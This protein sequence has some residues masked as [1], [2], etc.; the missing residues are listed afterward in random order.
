MFEPT[1]TENKASLDRMAEALKEIYSTA[2]NDPTAFRSM[3]AT[4]PVCRPDDV[5]A[6]KSM[7]LTFDL[8]GR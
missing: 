2:V 6:A 7:K 1:E 3:P 8:I 4:T 5:L